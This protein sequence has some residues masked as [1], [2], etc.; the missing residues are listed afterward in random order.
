M[1]IICITFIKGIDFPNEAL[2]IPRTQTIFQFILIFNSP[3][4]DHGGPRL[5][6]PNILMLHFIILIFLDLHE[7][8]L[9][10][11]EIANHRYLCQSTL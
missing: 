1:I 3:S 6:D 9:S 5:C 4:S 8:Y 11:T 10:S 2:L 7:I